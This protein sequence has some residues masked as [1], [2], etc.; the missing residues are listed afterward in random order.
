MSEISKI[1]IRKKSEA[2]QSGGYN[3]TITAVNDHAVHASVMTKTSVPAN[4]GAG[5]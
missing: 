5:R 2:V 3:E 1:D 4:P